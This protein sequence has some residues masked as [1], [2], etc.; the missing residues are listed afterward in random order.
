MFHNAVHGEGMNHLYKTSRTP[1]SAF[2]VMPL[3]I[4]ALPI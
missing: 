2:V 1:I 3:P 4:L